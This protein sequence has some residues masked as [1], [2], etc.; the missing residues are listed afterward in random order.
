MLPLVLGKW[1]LFKRYN[2][3]ETAKRRLQETLSILGPAS[4]HALLEMS[5]IDKNKIVY[6]F[7][8]GFLMPRSFEDEQ[9]K[10]WVKVCVSDPEI[11]SFLEKFL[12]KYE[13]ERQNELNEI[14][15]WERF[16]VETYA[17]PRAYLDLIDAPLGFKSLLYHII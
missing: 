13:E 8:S 14:R 11:K 6:H 3:E 9:E 4:L 10:K 5:E 17:K 2:Q 15:D 16:I 1:G 7:T 12:R